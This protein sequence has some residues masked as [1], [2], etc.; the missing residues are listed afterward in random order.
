[1]EKD[2]KH[3]TRALIDENKNEFELSENLMK[4]ITNFQDNIHDTAINYHRQ[5]RDKQTIHSVLDEIDG[6]RRSKEKSFI[7]EI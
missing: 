1:M 3:G 4:V 2:D 7:K 6:N 5:L